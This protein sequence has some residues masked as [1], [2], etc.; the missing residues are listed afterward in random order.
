M[1]LGSLRRL[2]PRL[3]DPLELGGVVCRNRLYRAPLLECAGNGPDA[4]ETLIEALEPAAAAGA[5]FIFQGA[6]LVSAK[7]GCAA[8]QMTRAHD[9]SFTDELERLTSTIQSHGCR[10]FAQLEHGGLRSM[11]TWH[12]E[13]R[14]MYPDL[15]QSAVSTPPWPLRFLDW[16]DLLELSPRILSTGAVRE[17]A[18]D[19]GRTAARLADAGYDG[20]HLAGANMGII[21]QFLSPHYNQRD[22][23]FGGSFENR[24]RF[25]EIIGREIRDRADEITL[26]TKIPAETAAPPFVRRYIDRESAVRIAERAEAA[27][28]D[29]V[30]PVECS[31]Y[32]DMSIARG[33]YPAKAWND[34]QFRSGYESAFGSW[35][36][37]KLIAALTR[38]TARWHDREPAWNESLCRMVRNRV[39]IPVLLEGGVRT[40]ET[41]DRLL[42]SGEME[43]A[44]DAV[45][46]GRPFYAEPRLPARLLSI[47]GRVACRSCNNCTVPQVTSANGMCRTPS[48]LAERGRR[49]R[50]GEYDR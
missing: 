32:W 34:E 50:N 22:D 18:A 17:L 20:I 13:Y 45:G 33:E 31:T 44:C 15:H 40:R 26:V 8:P 28:F 14:D 24:V 6:M 1:T 7:G 16:I 29:A 3:E 21:Q 4:V 12:N 25:L 49:E 48:V 39:D 9:P 30:V 23:A 10:L 5:G 38:L 41:I 11:E 47:G 42:G 43:P 46:L 35:S 2:V 27:G 37:T 19:F 36:R